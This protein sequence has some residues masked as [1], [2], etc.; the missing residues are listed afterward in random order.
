MLVHSASPGDAVVNHEITVGTL[1]YNALTKALDAGAAVLRRVLPGF[2]H[3]DQQSILDAARRETGLQDWG[4]DTF[5]EPMSRVIE[6]VPKERFTELA[7]VFMRATFTQAVKNRLRIQAY[8]KEHPEIRDIPIERPIFV[9]GFPRSGTT[10]L[11]NLLALDPRRRA[12][13]FWE[14]TNPVPVHGDPEVDV[15]RRIRTTEWILRLAYLVAPEMRYVH[16]IGATTA[17]E[18]WPLFENNFTVLNFDLQSGARGYG[19]WL[20]QHDMA[21][22]YQYYRSQLQL[23]LH[24]RPAE[25]L[26]LKCPEHLWFLDA[27]LEVFP[28]AC[29]IWTHRDPYDSV[30]SYCSLISLSWRMLYGRVDREVLGEHIAYRFASG[31]EAAM[32][33]RDRLGAHDRIY[34]LHFGELVKDPGG[35]LQDIS[36]YFDLDW[37]VDVRPAVRNYLENERQDKRGAHRYDGAFYG[38]DPDDIY[39]RFAEYI[40]RFAIPVRG[41]VPTPIAAPARR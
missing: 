17:E 38:L 20:Q 34:D 19:D 29:V 41:H 3:L 21:P 22:A 37:K 10:L 13:Q 35:A 39:A 15:R 8:L 2:S 14:L 40:Q 5:L 9:L 4:E 26:V 16:E 23:L 27:L 11:Q 25:Q 12:L 36:R 28:D 30:A 31:V 24:R 32:R 6:E 33:A 1:E 18:C 7:R